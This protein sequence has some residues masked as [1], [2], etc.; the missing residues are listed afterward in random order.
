[1]VVFH[2]EQILHDVA[3]MLLLHG[4]TADSKTFVM[5]CHDF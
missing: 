3:V 2:M 4:E 5:I 1:M